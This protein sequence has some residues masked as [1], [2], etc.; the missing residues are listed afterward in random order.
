MDVIPTLYGGLP[1]AL[2]VLAASLKGHSLQRWRYGAETD[3]L[4]AEALRRE[5]WP[6]RRWSEWHRQRLDRLVE[7]AARS[8][9]FYRTHVGGSEHGQGSA[10]TYEDF[11]VLQKEILRENPESFLVE[12]R[13]SRDLF[14]THTSGSTGTPL[15]LWVSRSSLRAWYAL[16]EARWRRW[17]GCSRHDRWAIIGGNLVAQVG[18]RKPPYWVWNAPMKQLY[19]SAYHV[20]PWSA[21]DIVQAMVRARVVY[22]WG[23]ASALTALSRAVRDQGLSPPE[24]R[25]VISNAEPLYDWQRDVI[26]RAFGCRVVNTYGMSEMVTAASE[27]EYGRMHLWPEAGIV[28]VLDGEDL[29]VEPGS[30]GRLVCTGLI[31]DAMPLIRYEVGDIG[32]VAPADEGC[33]CGRT[34]PILRMVEGR[35]DDVIVTPD[36]RMVGRLDTAFKSDLPI[37]A[38]QIVQEDRHEVRVLLVPAAGFSSK[39]IEGVRCLVAERLGPEMR[40]HV[41]Q[42]EDIPKGPNGKRRL[43]VS[44]VA[45]TL[46]SKRF[47]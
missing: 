29:P 22:L 21:R 1:Y 37:R 8:V 45:T 5:T 30:V 13:A 25:V 18:R 36:D 41:E 2:K 31:N 9:P 4:V 20:A 40:V 7:V 32:A 33:P 16:F 10:P 38:A 47:T 19:V 17:N 39:T 12:S 34:L 15:R 24:L 46:R 27:C 43:V 42:V 28:E 3:G 44:H 26:S 23:Y 6:L 14:L 11:P 35:L